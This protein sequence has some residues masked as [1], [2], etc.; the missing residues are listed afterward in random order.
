[1]SWRL[2]APEIFA[3]PPF[4][5]NAPDTTGPSNSIEIALMRQPSLAQ[6]L[7]VYTIFTCLS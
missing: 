1:M 2:G 7:V 4:K 3:Y 6:R 5:P